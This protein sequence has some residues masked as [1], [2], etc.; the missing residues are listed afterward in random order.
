MSIPKIIWAIW[1]N[2]DKYQDGKLTSQLTYFK[3]RLTQQHREWQVNIILEWNVLLSYISEDDILV[4]IVKNPNI[5]Q[6][7]KSDVIR[8]FLLKKYGGFWIDISTFLFTS[9]NIY[10]EKQPT[11]NFICYYTPPFMIEE[12]IFSSLSEMFDS[13]KFSE[14]VSKFKP[15]QDKYIKLNDKYKDFPFIPENFFIA[16]VPAHPIMIDIY[17]QLRS[18]WRIS[19]PNITDEITR[20]AEIDLLMNKLG[21]E[22][23]E[24]NTLDHTLTKTYDMTDITNVKFFYH[25]LDNTWNCGYVFNYLQMYIAIINYI[26]SNNLRITQEENLHPIFSPYTQDLC[27]VDENID[28]CKNIIV[29]NDTDGSTL[30][31]LSLSYNRLIK[32]AD[33]EPE[34]KNFN[35]T[36]IQKLINNIG[37]NGFT[38]EDMIQQ[39]VDWG[40]YQIK[41]SSWTRDADVILELE[42]LFPVTTIERLTAENDPITESAAKTNPIPILNAGKSRKSRKSRKSKKSRKSRK[43]KKS[44]R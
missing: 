7:H 33:I 20:C 19:M 35:N 14:I 6:Q 21:D 25:L 17:E 16:S 39:I 41:F 40:I 18:F 4:D 30:Y 37:N 31:L 32:W 12:I 8:F 44:R 9:L 5:I 34:R 27:S 42:K 15:I 38:K 26:K 29:T 43:S 22:V 36:L 23:F 1:V 3:N 13:I 2:F 10:Y 28:A 11:A 24:I